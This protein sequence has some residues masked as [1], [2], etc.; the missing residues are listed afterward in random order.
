MS[1][2]W[3]EYLKWVL[4][5]VP[6]V[7]NGM[8]IDAVREA[9]IDFCKVSRHYQ[10]TSF[11]VAVAATTTPRSI[12]VAPVANA[13]F[14][15]PVAGIWHPSISVSETLEAKTP[16]EFDALVPGW[17]S[18][19]D[20]RGVPKYLTTR[21]ENVLTIGPW[22]DADGTIDYTIAMIPSAD[23]TSGP[24]GLFDV[25]HMTI[26]MGAKA[27]LFLQR[28]KWGDPKLGASLYAEFQVRAANESSRIDR[29][30]TNAPLRTRSLHA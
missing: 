11:A 29:G 16:V 4:P 14:F 25:H 7:P 27:L 22:P 9:A 8:A 30:R 5:E 28:Q 23:S 12:T 21:D 20:V 1:V 10:V 15:V 24:D 6:G 13:K 26:A 19:N 17:R 18:S 3:S 2:A